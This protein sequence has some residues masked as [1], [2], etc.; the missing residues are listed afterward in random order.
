[1]SLQSTVPLGQTEAWWPSCFLGFFFFLEG[2]KE[3]VEGF[4]F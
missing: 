1:L 2:R 4:F 3:K